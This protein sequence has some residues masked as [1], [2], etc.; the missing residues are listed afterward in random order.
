[1]FNFHFSEH[2]KMKLKAMFNFF[3][4]FLTRKMKKENLR[5]IF[6]FSRKVKTEK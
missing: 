5:S 4:F 3:I 6:I 1:M 2:G